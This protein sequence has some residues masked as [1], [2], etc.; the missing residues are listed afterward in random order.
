M[1]YFLPF[2]LAAFLSSSALRFGGAEPGLTLSEWLK[3]QVG[4]CV[5]VECR[6]VGK[7]RAEVR[8]YSREEPIEPTLLLLTERFLELLAPLPHPIL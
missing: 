6:I 8:L 1:Y 3:I 2:F 7:H 4:G 5:S